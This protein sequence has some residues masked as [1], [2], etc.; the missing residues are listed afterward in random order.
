MAGKKELS[1]VISEATEKTLTESQVLFDAIFDT[2]SEVLSEGESLR[3]TGFGTFKV[4]ESAARQGRNPHTG[5]TIEI[6]AKN[7][8]QFSAGKGLKDAVK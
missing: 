2:A 5:E 7:R 4:V 1:R 3:F 6:P 8:V